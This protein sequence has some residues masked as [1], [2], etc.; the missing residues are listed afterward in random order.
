[1]G[2]GM[3]RAALACLMLGLWALGVEASTVLIKAD[4]LFNQGSADSSGIINIDNAARVWLTFIVSPGPPCA[5][6]GDAGTDTAIVLYVR[7]YG[8]LSRASGQD[9]SGGVL[10]GSNNRIPAALSDT[11]VIPWQPRY[12]MTSITTA[13]SVIVGG[14]GAPSVSAPSI[15]EYVVKIPA[16]TATYGSNARAARV[17]FINATTCAPLREQFAYFRWRMVAGPTVAR[18]RVVLGRENW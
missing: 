18:L 7:A 11:T 9:S 15:Y 6:Y 4:T 3:L 5:N 13:D 17:D 10:G 12:Q 8:V 14:G 1:M 16:V 2:K